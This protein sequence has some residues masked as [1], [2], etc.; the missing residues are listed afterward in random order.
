MNGW[1][2]R[3]LPWF[4]ALT[5]TSPSVYS[6]RFVKP[7]SLAGTG[8]DSTARQSEP[9]PAAPAAVTPVPPAAAAAAA[10]AYCLADIATS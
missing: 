3:K 1:C 5:K 7:S 6:K 9:A 10:S 4:A 2:P 8:V